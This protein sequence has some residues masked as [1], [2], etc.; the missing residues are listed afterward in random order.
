MAL[1]GFQPFLRI[2][3][4]CLV[5]PIAVLSRRWWIDGAG[6]VARTAKDEAFRRG[7]PDAAAVGRL[8]V[9]DMIVF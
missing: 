4:K 7:K 6:I 2:G 3:R 1:R 8:P 5:R 9:G